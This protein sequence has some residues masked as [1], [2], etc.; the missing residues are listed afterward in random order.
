MNFL[1]QCS[2]LENADSDE[3]F[4]PAT[5]KKSESNEVEEFNLS[6]DDNS[7]SDQETRDMVR[8]QNRKKKKSGGFQSM[9]KPT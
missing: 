1:H 8:E 5:S 7:D 2:I 4:G 3:D 9:G 6:S